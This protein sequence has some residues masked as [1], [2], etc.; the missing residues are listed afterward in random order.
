ME[1][2]LGQHNSNVNKAI[3]K[4]AAKETNKSN[5]RIQCEFSTFKASK[6]KRHLKTHSGEKSYTWGHLKT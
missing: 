5:R 3:V 1:E 4:V 2:T 6:L